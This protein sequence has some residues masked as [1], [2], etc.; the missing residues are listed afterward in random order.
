M[1]PDEPN[2][3]RPP[4]P[5][6]GR[7]GK[8]SAAGKP[9]PPRDR[10][11]EALM[12][13]A[14]EREWDDFGI[15]DIAERAG[16]SLADFRDAFPSK[17]AVLAAFSRKIDRLVLDGT[18]NALA[19]EAPRERLFDILMRR[20]DALA[21]YKLALQSVADWIRRDPLSATALNG[22]AMNSMRFMLVASGIDN[23]GPTG[24][25][26]LQGLVLAWSRVLDVWFDD[27]DAGLARTM[28]ALDKELVRG[29]TLVAR[30]D[31]LDRLV[32]PLRL[33]GRALI[34][35]RRRRRDRRGAPSRDPGAD[36]DADPVL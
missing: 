23:E 18:G 32:S 20:L 5:K 9:V 30:I 27:D 14:A 28:A 16:L 3:A 19:E 31:D 26:K 8:V 7:G 33:L 6:A 22:V 2:D 17:G 34:D 13:L 29:A 1:T 35:A 21:P 36:L 15:A 25:I 12:D 10:I 11:I 4:G 24:P